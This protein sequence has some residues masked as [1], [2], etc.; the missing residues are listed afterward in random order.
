M[1]SIAARFATTAATGIAVALI[2]TSIWC[3]R[4]NLR[5][6]EAGDHLAGDVWTAQ[7]M[8][9]RLLSTVKDAE[10]GQRGYLLTRAPSYL[11]PY[12]AAGKRLDADLA[13]LDAAPP[14]DRETAILIRRIEV[15]TRA[16]MEELRRTVALELSGHADA[17]LGTVRTNLGLKL[18]ND[19]RS[20]V[21]ALG[22]VAEAKI[23]TARGLKASVFRWTEVVGF[24]VLASVLMGGVALSQ[25]LARVQAAAS[26]RR[27]ERFTRAFGLTQ[28]M[29]HDLDGRI[30]FWSKGAERLYG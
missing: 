17:A 8:A 13:R 27:L 20:D 28:G 10:T 24:G 11:E 19:I 7:L 6:T 9:E 29:M 23:T 16:K 15:S 12:N 26:V 5:G 25:R 1:N 30:T 2:L 3:A 4:D 18:M 22:V 21:A 14:A